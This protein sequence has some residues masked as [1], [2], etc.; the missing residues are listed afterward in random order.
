MVV[1]FQDSKFIKNRFIFKTKRNNLIV[2]ST[3]N[4]LMMNK[5]NYVVKM[6]ENFE[7]IQKKLNH[8][9]YGILKDDVFYFHMEVKG[10]LK[11]KLPFSK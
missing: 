9:L 2:I 1:I 3:K 5:V 11:K 7:Q 10:I 8:K 4:P 6:K